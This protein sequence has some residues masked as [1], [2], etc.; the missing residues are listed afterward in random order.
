MSSECNELYSYAKQSYFEWDACC[1]I[2]T[3]Q[4]Y[5]EMK[6]SKSIFKKA[7]SDT[8]WKHNEV[9]L[10]NN[11]L[12]LPLLTKIKRNWNNVKKLN[13]KLLNPVSKMDGLSDPHN[14]V[15]LIIW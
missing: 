15:N 8:D 4:E 3:G 6:C 13:P 5:E 9:N 12:A 10:R 11:K 2:R 1:R 14:I 7:L